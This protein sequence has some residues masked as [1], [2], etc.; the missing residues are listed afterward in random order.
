MSTQNERIQQEFGKQA[1]RWNNQRHAAASQEQLQWIV[2]NLDLP[3]GA[4]VLDVATGTGLIGRS[5]AP[6][7]GRVVGIDLT[8][9]MLRQGCAEAQRTGISN[10]LFIQGLAE[11]LPYADETFDQVVSRFSVHHFDSPLVQIRE[12]ARVCRSG[13]KITIIDIVSPEDPILAA[14]Y[15]ALEKLRDPSHVLAFSETDLQALLRSVPLDVISTVSRDVETNLMRWFELSDT[16]RDSQQRIMGSLRAELGGGEIS[17]M[18]PFW[19]D[20]D[21]MFTHKWVIVVGVKNKN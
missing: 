10:I 13:G 6:H 11:T 21:V 12:M 16:P 17:G 1:A 15:N 9:K 20:Y 5:I 8:P 4:T 14:R 19:S 7:V 18:R 3:A 2:S